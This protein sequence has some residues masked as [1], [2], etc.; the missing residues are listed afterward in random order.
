MPEGETEPLLLATFQEQIDLIRHSID[1]RIYVK[2]PCGREIR[3]LLYAF[4]QYSQ[5]MVLVDAEETITTVEVDEE[6]FEEV[7]KTT[8]RRLHRLILRGCSVLLVSLSTTTS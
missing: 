6:T 1:K 3:G 8:K 4:D 5:N 7:Y 2:M